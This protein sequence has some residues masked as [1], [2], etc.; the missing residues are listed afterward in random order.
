MQA[1]LSK[2]YFRPISKELSNYEIAKYKYL[3]DRLLSDNKRGVELKFIINMK[4]FLELYQNLS[5][6]FQKTNKS[7]RRNFQIEIGF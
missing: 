5:K 2:W 1:S 3:C 6:S 7:F 4:I